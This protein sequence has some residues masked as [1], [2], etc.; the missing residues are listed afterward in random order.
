MSEKNKD[1]SCTLL[2]AQNSQDVLLTSYMHKDGIKS[3]PEEPCQKSLLLNNVFVNAP[4]LSKKS[5]N[6]RDKPLKIYKKKEKNVWV[7]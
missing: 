6:R 5:I 2:T 4:Y 7:R 3:I 1:L